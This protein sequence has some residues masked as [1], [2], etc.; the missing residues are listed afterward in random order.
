MIQHPEP[1]EHGRSVTIHSP[2]TPSDK[3]S[4]HDVD[5]IAT[6]TP[7]SHVPDHLTAEHHT[8]TPELHSEPEFKP[9]PHLATAAG[10]IIHN[11]DGR[12]W[13][14]SPTNKFGGYQNTF[15]KGRHEGGSLSGT[16]VREVH[17]E[18]G[19]HA[20]I[21]A[22]LGDYDRTTTRTRYYVGER[23]SGSPAKM[24]WES[25]AMHL[26]P[27]KD[28]HH[29]MDTPQDKQIAKDFQAHHAKHRRT[30]MLKNAIRKKRDGTVDTPAQ[31]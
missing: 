2:H 24:G 4:W 16:A 28:L 31:N 22:H 1:D 27:I 29:F 3:S 8:D 9:H 25:Q 10:A 12:V 18:T 23:V 7:G 6:F 21:T 26:V 30:E 19:I 11:G 17:E 5:R 14:K 15:P 20:K 13:V